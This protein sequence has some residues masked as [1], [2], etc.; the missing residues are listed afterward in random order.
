MMVLLL[1]LVATLLGGEAA[2]ARLAQ[3]LADADSVDSV[4][5]DRSHHVVTFRIDRAGEAYEIVARTASRGVVEAIAIRDAGRGRHRLG[6]LSWLADAM[7]D[8]ESVVRLDVDEA[9]VVTLVTNDGTRYLALPG[10]GAIH[11]DAVEARWG[12]EWNNS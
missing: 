6:K 11:N 3:A 12:G 1:P 7:R 2:Q 10:H 8:T 9:G 4:V 5:V